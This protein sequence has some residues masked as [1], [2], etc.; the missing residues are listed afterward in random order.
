MEVAGNDVTT[1]NVWTFIEL[2]QDFYVSMA[3]KWNEAH[4]D[5]KVQ[6]VLSNMQYDD[7]H[8]KLSLA[9]ES[10][11]GAPD[12]VDIELGKFPAFMVGKIGLME[13]NDVIE[14]YRSNIVQSR[15]DIYSKDGKEYGLPTHVVPRLHSIMISF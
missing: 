5:K 3:E 13:L 10:G 12:I 4:P 2:H 9:L 15:L 1:L 8:N 11:E 6:L 7:M 14:P